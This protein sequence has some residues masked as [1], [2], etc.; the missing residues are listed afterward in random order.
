MI[1]NIYIITSGKIRP[2][3]ARINGEIAYLPL[4]FGQEKA[5][6]LPN[7]QPTKAEAEAEIVRRKVARIE[8][9]RKVLETEDS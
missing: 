7:W 4:P 3:Q 6:K 5:V 2:I 9:A 1:Q 8:R